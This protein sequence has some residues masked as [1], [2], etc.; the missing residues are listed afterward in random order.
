MSH[1]LQGRPYATVDEVVK[2]TVLVCDT[3]FTCVKENEVKIVK[4]DDGCKFFDCAAGSHDISGQLDE[5][6]KF[7]IGLYI[8]TQEE[9]LASDLEGDVLNTPLDEILGRVKESI[10]G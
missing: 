6:G 9:I 7:Y 8:A 4:E 5:T 3:S 1:D 10:P 2:G